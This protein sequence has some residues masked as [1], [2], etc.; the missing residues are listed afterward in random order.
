MAWRL[1][2]LLTPSLA[3]DFEASWQLLE[4]ALLVPA[5]GRWCYAAPDSLHCCLP[6]LFPAQASPSEKGPS[7][8]TLSAVRPSSFPTTVNGLH[9]K[10][11][12]FRFGVC[13]LLLYVGR[14]PS[15]LFSAVRTLRSTCSEYLLEEVSERAGP[16]LPQ[17]LSAQSLRLCT[18]I[19]AG[20][21]STYNEHPIREDRGHSPVP[22]RCG[23]PCSSSYE[24]CPAE[25]GKETPST[26]Q[27]LENGNICHLVVCQ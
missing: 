19:F 17:L 27:A 7:P 1:R 6:H 10:C 22:P 24:G 26:C 14:V 16:C 8:T 2:T 20:A 11:F 9:V 12:D 13:W 3:R 4:R 23:R 25:C 5:P 15:V 21:Q 18:F